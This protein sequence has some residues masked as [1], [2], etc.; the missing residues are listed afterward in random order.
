[1]DFKFTLKSSP[2]RP[3]AGGFVLTGKGRLFGIA[4]IAVLAAFC[5]WGVARS[6]PH[7][8]EQRLTAQAR[9]FLQN[10]RCKEAFLT[11]QQ[12]LTANPSNVAACR[13]MAELTQRAQDPSTLGWRRQVAQLSPT[14]ENRLML[15]AAALL[16]ERPPFS[17][18]H[19]TLES[20]QASHQ[21]SA[22]YHVI[23]AQLA[24]KLDRLEEAVTHYQE[25]IKLEPHK[26]SHQLNLAFLRLQSRDPQVAADSRAA[27]ERLCANPRMRPF[28]LRSLVS[29]RLDKKDFDLARQFSEQLLGHPQAGFGDRVQH[30]SILHGSHDPAI[31]TFLA[32]V[33][34]EASTNEL[35]VFQVSSWMNSRGMADD[36]L[37][38]IG[39][40]ATDVKARQPVP[41]AVVECLRAKRDW[42]KLESFLNEQQWAE[43]DFVRLTLLALALRNQDLREAAE[44]RLKSAV[45]LASKRVETLAVL[46]Q[47]LESWGWQ[48]EADEMLQLLVKR[49]P[50]ERWATRAVCLAYYLKGN[51]AGLYEVHSTLLKSGVT[52]PTTKNDFAMFCLLLNTNLSQAHILAEEAYRSEPRN[53]AFVST[54][55]LS[56]QVQGKISEA[57]AL[58]RT[59]PRTNLERPGTALHYAMALAAAGEIEESQKFLSMVKGDQL[60]PEERRLLEQA[61]QRPK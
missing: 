53:P 7:Y 32:G 22:V 4:G 18:A 55:A 50:N 26:E 23:A 2:P 14:L 41:K 40:L 47:M 56:L 6:Y 35:E 15:A 37:T 60:L 34:N 5:F 45:Q 43:Q 58:F 13:F 54:R 57:L 19:A 46:A 9:L 44:L 30:L 33:Q 29:D 27:I 52:D 24:L 38:W 31:G 36:A 49:F 8:K 20:I 39:T 42:S 17:L 51:T 12:I 11:A 10:G 61:K 25:A 59:L 16:F 1:M 21:E 28:A 3:Y 48:T